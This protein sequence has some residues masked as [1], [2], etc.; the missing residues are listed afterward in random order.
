MAKKMGS[1]LK[2][3]LSQLSRYQ[4]LNVSKGIAYNKRYGSNGNKFK[5]QYLK[6]QVTLNIV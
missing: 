4:K 6:R 5:W 1:T 3:Q 2:R